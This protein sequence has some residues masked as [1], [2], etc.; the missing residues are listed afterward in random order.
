MKIFSENYLIFC[1][2]RSLQ[3]RGIFR[4]FLQTCK[5]LKLFSILGVR[6]RYSLSQLLEGVFY[7]KTNTSVCAK[8]Q[9]INFLKKV[10]EKV[11]FSVLLNAYQVRGLFQDD[12]KIK[13][14]FEKTEFSPF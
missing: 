7:T 2:S 10:S 12:L 1:L 5:F 4:Q 14:V 9:K 6:K 13:K 8:L 11:V 3:V